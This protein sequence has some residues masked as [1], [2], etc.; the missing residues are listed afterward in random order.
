LPGSNFLGLP[1][2][3]REAAAFRRSGAGIVENVIVDGVQE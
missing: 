1:A 2:E 3:Y